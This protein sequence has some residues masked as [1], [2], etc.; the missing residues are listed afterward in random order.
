MLPPIIVSVEEVFDFLRRA[1][2]L[3]PLY[4]M[5]LEGPAGT[6]NA[7]LLVHGLGNAGNIDSPSDQ[8]VSD[9]FHGLLWWCKKINDLEG[10]H[11][12]TEV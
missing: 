6:K 2:E 5:S 1:V 7:Y 12:P 10:A 9:N 4:S 11:A 8:P 3:D